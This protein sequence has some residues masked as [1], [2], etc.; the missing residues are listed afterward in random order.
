MQYRSVEFLPIPSPYLK[1][2]AF[3]ICYPMVLIL[4]GNSEIVAQVMSNLCNLIRL[5]HQLDREQSQIGYFPHACATRST[6]LIFVPWVYIINTLSTCHG[7]LIDIFLY[8]VLNIHK[9]IE[10]PRYIFS[11][12]YG[13]FLETKT[14]VKC[15]RAHR[16]FVRGKDSMIVEKTPQGAMKFQF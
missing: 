16:I 6:R 7:E 9:L 10:I 1:T 15:R 3:N 4:D 14:F 13:Q 12:V 5:L 2:V 11:L 8:I